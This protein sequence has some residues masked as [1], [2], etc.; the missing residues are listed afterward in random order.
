MR[1][2]AAPDILA[3][4]HP[5]VLDAPAR[6]GQRQ[7]VLRSESFRGFGSRVHGGRRLAYDLVAS[8]QPFIE[9]LLSFEPALIKPFFLHSLP[10]SSERRQVSGRSFVDEDEVQSKT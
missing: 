2:G 1:S 3:E 8:A 6:Q 4:F 9:C 10:D 7:G 5:P